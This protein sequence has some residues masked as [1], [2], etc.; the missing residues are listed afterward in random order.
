MALKN[1]L[2]NYAPGVVTSGY[3]YSY[4]IDSVQPIKYTPLDTDIDTEVVIIGGGISGMSVAY[5]LSQAGRKVV[6]LEDGFIGSGETGRTTAH[7]VNALDDRFTSI[8]KTHGEEGAKLVAESH[9]AAID[10]IENT[11]AKENFTCDFIRLDGYLFL[12]AT[13][14]PKTLEDELTATQKAGLNTTLILGVPGIPS[15]KGLCLHFPQQAQM[16]PLK[17]LKGLAEAIV[18]NGGKIFTETH[19]DEI[20][21]KQVKAK[22]FT[23]KADHIVVATNSPINDRV[24]MHTKQ[25]PYRSYVIGATLPKGSVASALWWDTGDQ[26]SKWITQPYHYVRL[27]PYN[28]QYDLLICGGEDHKTAQADNEKIPEEERYKALENW[29]A[30]RFPSINEIVY[31]WSG[32]VLEPL[33]HLAFIGRNPGD[34]NIYIATGDSGNGMTH[35]VIAGILI[36]DLINGKENPWEKLYSPGRIT[37]KVTPEYLSE[38][39]KMAAQYLDFVAPGDIESANELKYEEGGILNLGLKKIAVYKDAAGLVHAF[40]AICP[41]LGCVVQWNA[42][43]KSFDCPCHGSRFTCEGKVINGPASTDLKPI[44][45]TEKMNA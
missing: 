2:K 21:K 1:N 25:F 36:T 40:N 32:Q 3:N 38:V 30:K 27:Q 16:H 35:G 5:C 17:Y 24:T 28:N 4:W 31:R 42:S 10:F 19:V 14:K 41:H 9:T 33:D 6:V 37:L 39:G 11:I 26:N 12:H 43:E 22:G 13:D 7:L 18:K 20:E 23:V 45:V 29:A 15:E 8:E 34:A 44:E